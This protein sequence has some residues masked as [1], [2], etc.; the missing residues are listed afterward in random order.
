MNVE[1]MDKKHIESSIKFIMRSSM[2]KH[3]KLSTILRYLFVNE[4]D[5]DQKKYFLIGS[6]TIR[7]WR[8]INDLNIIIVPNEFIKLEQLVTIGIG[9][10][11]MYNGGYR[12]FYDMTNYYNEITGQHEKKFSIEAYRVNERYGFPDDRFSLSNLMKIGGLE[13]DE[14]DHLF[15]RLSILL[16]WKKTM[17]RP[18]DL[19]DIDI[20]EKI[21]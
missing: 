11:E 21:L 18:K 16:I 20:I 8:K 10:M 7:K 5:I 2:E 9:K 1:G 17:N 3:N 15:L 4:C 12:W 6:Y 13:L 14:N 19:I